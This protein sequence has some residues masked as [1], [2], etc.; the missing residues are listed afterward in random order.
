M[1]NRFIKFST[2]TA[3]LLFAS[4]TQAAKLE[5]KASATIDSL[6]KLE[7]HFQLNG[8]AALFRTIY[9]FDTQD[10][11]L[12]QL[13]AIIRFRLAQDDSYDSTVKM[14]PMNEGQLLDTSLTSK[15]G[16]KCE[17]DATESSEVSSCSLTNQEKKFATDFSANHFLKKAQ[18]QFIENQLAQS[19]SFKSLKPF[20]P[21]L[22]TT[23]K[24]IAYQGQ[25]L[26]IELWN[27]LDYQFLELSI[28]GEERQKAQLQQVMQRLFNELDLKADPEGGQK[29]SRAL[30]ILAQK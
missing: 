5:F 28:K 11:E 23:Y 9:F 30:E 20:G 6:P 12:F 24:D 2:V 18:K 16:F 17:I 7:R 4:T 22:S 19:I 1:I 25:A 15:D 10:L 13:G 14:R 21:I 8:D 29:T 27:V 3:F 26:T